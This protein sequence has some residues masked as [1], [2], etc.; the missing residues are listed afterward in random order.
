MKKGEKP[1]TLNKSA[2]QAVVLLLAFVLLLNSCTNNLVHRENRHIPVSGWKPSDSLAFTF[3]IDD[4]LKP[5]NIYFNV[6]NTTD[7]SYQNLYFF[8]TTLYPG[9][10]FS[11]DT[12]Q[13][14][15]AGIDGKWLGKGKGKTRDS[16]LLF[17]KNVRFSR[18]GQYTLF[19]NQAM[20]E[21]LLKGVTD[22][23]LIIEQ[24]AENE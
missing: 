21:D 13:C 22:V 12:A 8:I 11:R 23:A 1:R 10:E 16:K 17:R 20:R 3:T 15:L 14:I 2:F 18:A 6:R 9:G 19:V 4:T 24:P 5:F 7:Y